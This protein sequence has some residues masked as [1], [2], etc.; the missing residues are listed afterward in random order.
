M[1]RYPLIE[2]G[3]EAAGGWAWAA[4]KINLWLEVL[5]R[6]EDGFHEVVTLLA[7]I[8]L[9]DRLEVTV[10][11]A[12]DRLSVKGIDVPTSADNLVLKALHSARQTRS[13]KTSS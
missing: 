3:L 4:A 8:A 11:G 2:H 10:S 7:P 9:C 6:R 13:S 12:A 1:N 5:N